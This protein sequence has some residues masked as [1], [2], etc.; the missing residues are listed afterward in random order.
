MSDMVERV[1]RA[2][3]Y[4]ASSANDLATSPRLIAAS[5]RALATKSAHQRFDEKL[6]EWQPRLA[7]HFVTAMRS[8]IT[9][10]LSDG[11]LE[12][13][14]ISPSLSSFDDLLLFLSAMPWV[15]TPAV[16]ITRRG[17]FQV[18]WQVKGAPANVVLVFLG[19][20]NVRWYRVDERVR[21]HIRHATGVDP[22]GS[23]EMW[24]AMIDAALK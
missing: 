3:T 8:H 17:E 24:R 10:L 11:E 12:E 2:M 4:V 19:D 13:D 16:G 9:R 21:A 20:R 5:A 7:P 6:S 23:F 15:K 1:A 14:G 22:L 18:S